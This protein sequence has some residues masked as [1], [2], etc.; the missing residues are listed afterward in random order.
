[1]ARFEAFLTV[2][3]AKKGPYTR[4]LILRAMEEAERR[5]DA[6]FGA[7]VQTGRGA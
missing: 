7:V 1:M 4:Q 3:G 6:G 5:G 2:R